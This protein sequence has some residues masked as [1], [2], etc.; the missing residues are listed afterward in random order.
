MFFYILE[1]LTGQKL[2]VPEVTQSEEN[3]K[4]KLQTVLGYANRVSCF[5]K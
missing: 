4:Q 3:Q 5:K 1:K 2:D